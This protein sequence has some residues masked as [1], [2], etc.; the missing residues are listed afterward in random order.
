MFRNVIYS[1]K[2]QTINLFTW[3][4]EGERKLEVHPFKPYLYVKKCDGTDGKS[5]YN[6]NLTKISFSS[7][8]EREKFAKNKKEVYYNISPEQQFLIEKFGK[9]NK[10]EDFSNNP[11]KTF[12]L[13]I[14]VHSPNEFPNPH[15]AKF[16]INLITVLDSITN[17]YH[18]FG[19]KPYHGA[20]GRNS[21]VYHYFDDEF[22]MLRAFLKF[23]RKDFPDIVTG[24]Y[25]DSFDI[26]YIINR[27][28]HL[29]SVNGVYKG[30]NASDRLSPLDYCFF[31]ENVE[32]RLEKY[33]KLWYIHG[34]TL[35]DYMYLYKV[36]TK[37]PRES[38]SLNHISEV[39]LGMKK[40]AVNKVSL[41]QLADEDWDSFVEYNIQDVRLIKLLEDKLRYLEI[42][43]KIGYLSL[44][45]FKRAE[46]TVQVVTGIIAQKALEDGK[47]ISTFENKDDTPF[48][49]G[50]VRE[51]K[52]GLQQDVLYFDV[53]S[54][55]PNTIVTLNLSPETKVASFREEDDNIFLKTKKGKEIKITREK[56]KTLVKKEELAISASNV[57][58]SQKVKGLAPSIIEEI[59]GERVGIIKNSK[60]ISNQKIKLSNAIQNDNSDQD[61]KIVNKIRQI[62]YKLAQDDTMQYVLKILLNKI[63][64]YFAEKSS[65]F[66]DLELAESIT[67]TGQECIKEAAN[68]VVQHIKNEYDMDYDCIVFG[69]TD[70]IGI[71]VHEVLKKLDIPLEKGGSINPE[72]FDLSMS[73]KSLIDKK[74]NAWAKKKLNSKWKNYVFKL[75]SISSSAIFVK[76]KN[77]V[78]EMICDEDGQS[79]YNEK[80]EKLRRKYKYTGLEVVKTSTPQ[81]L[82]PFLKQI[83]ESIMVKKDRGKVYNDIKKIYDTFEGF[84][85]EEIAVP[86]SLNN[87]EKYENMSVGFRMGK[88]TPIHVKSAIYYNRL[89][90]KHNLSNKY[91]RLKSG[92]KIKYIL[93]EKNQLGI[94]TMAFLYDF[95]NEFSFL[96]VDRSGMFEKTVIKPLN[97]IFEVLQWNIP[98]P[99]RGEKN[100]LLD[101]FS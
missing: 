20:D 88:H 10:T 39:E 68:V 22:E 16:P 24:W 11:L 17:V 30:K 82:K 67:H 74:I 72:V 55:Y 83:I 35:F 61:L 75:E 78:L 13:D 66:F 79:F 23:W 5:I 85:I 80:G 49:G 44:S 4:N 18:T 86:T 89:L 36:F 43:K 29:Y 48:K 26:P 99:T 51:S 95:P 58:F 96:D 70:S 47:I 1:G 9:V 57:L 27:V 53:N 63:Y 77:Y 25:S 40:N 92:D 62:D 90:E 56:F 91:E 41:A 59:Y 12:Y 3:D 31:I 65:P 87:Y 76:K 73:F 34:V 45:P 81:K 94:K 14:E 71:T 42:C 97:R 101:M 52:K 6:E 54:L 69:D 8:K 50:F 7:K 37:D 93:L 64:G 98:S 28:N 38:Y 19:T 21:I 46:S 15:E 33:E 32:K 100:N 60:K 84:S 2:D